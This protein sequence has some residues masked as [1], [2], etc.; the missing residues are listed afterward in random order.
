MSNRYGKGTTAVITGAAS[1]TGQAFCEKLNSHGFKL[2]L[3]DDTEKAADLEKLSQ[4]YQ[5][6]PTVTFD[7]KN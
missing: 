6:A 1:P 7:F 3:V 4:K 5:S 2:I